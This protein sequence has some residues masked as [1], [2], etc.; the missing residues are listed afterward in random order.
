M[1]DIIH[2]LPDAVAN[3]IAA[4]EVVQ[5]PSSIVKEMMENSIDAGAE[6]IRVLIVDG[7]KTNVQVIDDGKGMSETDARLS[8]ERH[9]TSKIHEASD[10]FNLTTM[11]FRGEALASIAAVAQIELKTRRKEDELGT[12]LQLAGSRIEKQEP[13][14]CPVGSNFSVQ[15]L[16]FNVPARRKFLKSNQTELANVVADF[17]R[18][19]LVHPDVSFSLYNN[20][21]EMHHLPQTSV[22]QRIVDVFGKKI[23]AELLPV[24][25]ETSLVRISGYVGKP[26]SSKK[27]GAHQYFFV[28]GRYM[29]HPYFHS[30]VM[31]AYENMIP[32][33]E[34]VSYFLYFSV[35][36]SAVD[37]NVHPTKTEIKFDN[38][39]PIWQVLSAAVK[40]TIGRFCNVPM[41]DFDVEG[42]P[43]IPVMGTDV[44]VPR[45]PKLSVSTY[46]PFKESGAR[47]SSVPAGWES[48]YDESRLPD[49]GMESTKMGDE[50]IVSSPL[51]QEMMGN[52]FEAVPEE[53]VLQGS[54][55]NDVIV[56]HGTSSLT[57]DASVPKFQ[58]KGRYIVLP[59]SE[60]VMVV[61]QHRAHV[62]VLFDHNMQCINTGNRPSQKELFPNVIQFDKEDALIVEDMMD[63]ICSLGFEL[64]NLGGGAYSI[65]GIPSGIEG[66]D[67]D[68]LLHDM[69]VAAKEKTNNI[70]KDA[71]EAMAL[72][73]AENAA[74][75]YGQVLSIAEMERLLQDLFATKTPARTPDGKLVYTI[76]DDKLL[77]DA[78]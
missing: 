68:S 21:V 22:R 12:M 16:F 5:R 77:N 20:G 15:N 38:E 30:A 36:P 60:G 46:N 3:Q 75:V 9:A 43:D 27:K 34:H 6:N 50:T 28:N 52:K 73:M 58:Y 74:I 72:T 67:I 44:T 7:G 56:E 61:N 19:V 25:V 18:I 41:I 51:E 35:E 2:L 24:D 65:N 31:K 32:T 66:V 11:G 54:I 45:Q 29:R 1:N 13:V 59:C 23:N 37:V 49:V 17:Q 4:G 33:G 76:W 26:E 57:V 53:R 55:W 70:K 62:R 40:E 47:S 71:Q 69:V 78:F 48:L 39:Q 14:M 10:L 63:D 64:S 42:R 8:F